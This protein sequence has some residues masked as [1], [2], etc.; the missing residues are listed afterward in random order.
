MVEQKEVDC[1]QYLVPPGGQKS[2]APHAVGCD[3]VQ[4]HVAE[5]GEGNRPAALPPYG[6]HTP[7][8]RCGVSVSP[9]LAKNVPLACFL[10]AR[11]SP[12]GSVGAESPFGKEQHS[13]MVATHKTVSI[14]KLK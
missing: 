4:R 3:W 9:L 13:Q 8:L 2:I 12:A 6:S 10:Y 7:Q 1:T 14:Y 11:F 5:V